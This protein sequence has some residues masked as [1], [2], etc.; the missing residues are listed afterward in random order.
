MRRVLKFLGWL[1][2]RGR[3]NWQELKVDALILLMIGA[4]VWILL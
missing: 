1:D 4:I 2:Y 3:I